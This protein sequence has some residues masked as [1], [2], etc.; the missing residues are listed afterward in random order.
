MK[1]LNGPSRSRRLA[2]STRLSLA[3]VAGLVAFAAS[4]LSQTIQEP[5]FYAVRNA[6][7][8]LGNG[9]VIEQGTIVLEKGLIT[10]VGA[11]IEV[12]DHAW[13]IEGDGLHAYPGLI[14][15][16]TSLG[17]DP[18]PPADTR[19]SNGGANDTPY[20]TGAEDRPGTFTWR[21][22]ADQLDGDDERIASW[23][24]AG[25]TSA[26]TAH[27]EGIFPGQASLINLGEGPGESLVVA[28]PI[29]FP[30]RL[31]AP[32]GYRG[33]PGSLMGV[34]AY[35]K[36]VFADAEYYSRAWEA[37][38]RDARGRTR[39]QYDRTLEPL[40]RAMNDKTPVWIPA[41]WKKEIAR[42]L[43]LGETIGSRV[44]V[45]GAH[46][47]YQMADALADADASVLLSA[48]WPEADADANPDAE[49]PLRELRLRHNAPTT[50]KA[51]A[52]AGVRFAFYSDG[53][54]S[55]KHLLDNVK[56]SIERGL[57]EQMA[58]QALSLNAAEIL[59]LSDRL[60]SL[61]AGKI[62]NVLVTQGGL[63]DEA[64]TI[65]SVFVDGR[66]FR[67]EPPAEDPTETRPS[68]EARR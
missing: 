50:P 26:V 21:S 55:G 7:I 41:V 33:Y 60:G 10:A 63:F 23:R 8:S 68:E 17:L 56:K 14:D 49:V 47:A 11:D 20:S 59:G 61:E 43:A 30:I 35:V 22:A 25:F 29:A 62:G 6:H 18:P 46:D 5:P 16:M 67:P 12:P 48:K 40:V 58:V 53:T 44:V 37:Y 1:E 57:D 2:P 54:K 32:G 42:A 52:D 13:V 65:H 31:E 3:V 39:P 51:L 36:Q 24:S 45:Y 9:Q 27:Q 64:M 66:Q 34:I 15:A 28:T 38:G 4:G 19:R